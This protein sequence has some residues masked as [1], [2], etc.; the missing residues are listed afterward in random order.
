MTNPF[1][2]GNVVSE[3]AFCNRRKELTEIVRVM[4]N[5]G[6]AFIYSERR[7]GKTSL[8]KLALSKL[9]RKEYITV[10]CDL[11]PTDGEESFVTTLAKALTESMKTTVQKALESAR[12]L[13]SHLSP[14]LTL[15]DEGKP[16]VTFTATARNKIIQQL[17]E[18]LAAATR[19]GA[20]GKKKVVIVFDEIQ[21]I[22]EYENDHVE[23]RLRSIIQH[24][25][26]VAYIFLGSRKHIVQKMFLDKS[27]PL[28][29]AAAHIP[30]SAIPEKEWELFI[31]QRF[32]SAK[33]Q[34][35]D[36][37]I[38]SLCE[39]TQGHPFYTQHL[40]HVVWELCEPSKS[41]SEGLI[42]D[43]VDTLLSRENHAYTVLWESLTRNQ[44]R[45]L[46]VLATDKKSIQLFASDFI[47]RAQLGSASNVQRVVDSLLS[48]DVIDRENGS[49]II[50]D[51]FL[52]LWIHKVQVVG[53]PSF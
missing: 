10:Y 3:E 34:I 28:Y 37:Q 21:Q 12:T 20:A 24:Q 19:I 44:Q 38:Q 43:A 4:E 32:L 1:Q 45:L 42:R 26:N 25:K 31:R 48:K 47:R 8:V 15:D 30:L 2:Y 53:A 35:A 41:V 14:S 13:F 7:M 17:D 49:Y 29:R 52:R 6:R 18:V 11:W 51:R 39:L 50:L 22:L 23:R 16:S 36:G 46:K 40:S 33:K 9:P 27:R 5:G